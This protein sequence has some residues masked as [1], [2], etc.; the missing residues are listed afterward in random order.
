MLKSGRFLNQL[1]C[2]RPF[3]LPEAGRAN[4]CLRLAA[5]AA[6]TSGGGED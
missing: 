2:V 4:T 3:A 5:F 1:N 6:S